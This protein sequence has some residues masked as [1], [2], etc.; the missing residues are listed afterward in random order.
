MIRQI[1]RLLILVLVATFA[2]TAAYADEPPPPPEAYY[3]TVM[4]YG[5]PAPVGTQVE[6]RG[7]GV[8]IGIDGNPLPVTVAG[9]YGGPEWAD[10][11][12]L[13]Q[14]TIQEGAALEFYVNGVKAECAAPGGLW[15]SSH[16]FTSG[17]V[18]ELNLRVGYYTYLPLS[19][20]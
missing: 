20:R 9:R 18:T 16:P 1:A 10:G 7:E 15:T 6:A 14:G 3:G 13:V 4:A 5:R 8:V 19:L 17:T 12:L 11:K 2:A